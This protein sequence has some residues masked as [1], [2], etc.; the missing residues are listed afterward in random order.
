MKNQKPPQ[1]GS[2]SERNLH[3]V[4]KDKLI[5]SLKSRV[6]KLEN[7][8]KTQKGNLFELE[9]II[10]KSPA[11]AF[12]WANE[13]GMPVLVVSDNV[14]ALGYEPAEMTSGAFAFENIIHPDDLNAVKND[15]SAFSAIR[16][17]EFSQQYRLRMKNGEYRFVNCSTFIRRDAKGRITHYQGVIIDITEQTVARKELTALGLD[18]MKNLKAL[19][20][21]E[22]RFRS[23][24]ESSPIG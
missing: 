14:I 16:R 7:E 15:I 22:V 1:N 9:N 23:L 10:N 20:E 18:N 4:D 3:N 12:L 24:Y 5:E 2:S 19:H 13:P 17:D 11:I 6:N 21:S 8:I